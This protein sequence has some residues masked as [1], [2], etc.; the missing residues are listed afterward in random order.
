MRHEEEA[1]FELFPMSSLPT[2]VKLSREVWLQLSGDKDSSTR[3]TRM[4]TPL[5]FFWLLSVGRLESVL[6]S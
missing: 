3:R 1:G 2:N 4:G 6:D 5:S